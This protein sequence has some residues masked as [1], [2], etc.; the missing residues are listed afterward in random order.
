MKQAIVVL[1]FLLLCAC[2]CEPRTEA[3]YDLVSLAMSDPSAAKTYLQ[4]TSFFELLQFPNARLM[5]LN[6]GEFVLE[7]SGYIYKAIP[8]IESFPRKSFPPT[9]IEGYKVDDRVVLI[10]SIPKMKREAPGVC[11]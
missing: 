1:I 10:N 2:F 9:T 8:L 11:I 4:S 7:G 3:R 6:N 5:V